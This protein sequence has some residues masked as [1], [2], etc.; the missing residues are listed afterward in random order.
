MLKRILFAAFVAATLGPAVTPVVAAPA[1]SVYIR[2]AP[3]P[4]RDEAVPR[5]RRGYDWS[6]GYW[7]WNNRQQ[8]HRWVAGSWMRS[9]PGYIYAQPSWVERDGRWEQRRGAWAR[10]DRDR[11][12]IP[13]ARDRDRD[14]DGVPNRLDRAPN[15]PR[16]D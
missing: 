1:S 12:G 13:N 6:P 10:G 3:P 2:I 7:N 15:N 5:A 16:R 4:P 14:G 9:R 11:D 8:R